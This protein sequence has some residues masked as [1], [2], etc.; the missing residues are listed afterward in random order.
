MSTY[1]HLCVF[2]LNYPIIF[3]SY[4]A[5]KSKI[6]F[7]RQVTRDRAIEFQKANKIDAFFETSAKT[8][9]NVEE[10]FALA[11]KQLYA[12]HKRDVVSEYELFPLLIPT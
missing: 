7:S 6:Y 11:A 10:V 8:G 4:C 1:C 12:I 2:S 5:L 9:N 3:S